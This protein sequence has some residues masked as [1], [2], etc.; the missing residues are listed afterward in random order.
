MPA[1]VVSI[2]RA[3]FV[4]VF[5]D[6]MQSVALDRQAGVATGLDLPVRAHDVFLD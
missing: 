3:D 4:A 1:A 2:R 5:E 6:R